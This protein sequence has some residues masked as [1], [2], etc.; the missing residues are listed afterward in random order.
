LTVIF[1]SNL[2]ARSIGENG[3]I[4]GRRLVQ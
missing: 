4:A 3:P 1:T 2:T